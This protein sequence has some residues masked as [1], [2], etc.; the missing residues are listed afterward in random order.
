MGAYT[1][2]AGD[3]AAIAAGM[4]EFYASFGKASFVFTLVVFL[5]ASV[6]QLFSYVSQ[7][8]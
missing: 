2:N 8:F 5:T 6:G 3:A 7:A 1:S 4:E